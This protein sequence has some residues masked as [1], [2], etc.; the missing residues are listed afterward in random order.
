MAI[1]IEDNEETHVVDCDGRVSLDGVAHVVQDMLYTNS[2]LISRTVAEWGDAPGCGLADLWLTN[3]RNESTELAYRIA[4]GVLDDII[5]LVWQ[6]GYFSGRLGGAE[7]P[8]E[9]EVS[10]KW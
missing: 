10:D 6:G 5:G 7:H 1:E 4:Q 8:Y 9:D 2:G 3:G